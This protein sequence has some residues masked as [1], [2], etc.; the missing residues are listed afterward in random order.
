MDRAAVPDDDGA[1]FDATPNLAVQQHGP[2]EV[3][4]S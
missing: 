3:S 2:S 4:V 1:E